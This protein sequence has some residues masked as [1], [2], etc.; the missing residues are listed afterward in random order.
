[1][2][3]LITRAVC[4]CVIVTITFSFICVNSITGNYTMYIYLWCACM[5]IKKN[6]LTVRQNVIDLNTQHP[7]CHNN[8]YCNKTLSV[9]V[10]VLKCTTQDGEKLFPTQPKNYNATSAHLQ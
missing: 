9:C 2:N 5:C 3:L 6:L 10:C 8:Y 1:M 4:T 7:C